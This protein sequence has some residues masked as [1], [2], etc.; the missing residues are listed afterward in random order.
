MSLQHTSPLQHGWPN[1][2]YTLIKEA[3]DYS[4][5]VTAWPFWRGMD[6]HSGIYCKHDSWLSKMKIS[7]THII[8]T[9]SEYICE[10]NSF[11]CLS[12]SS[13]IFTDEIGVML[14]YMQDTETITA[15]CWS[16]L[17]FR[18]TTVCNYKYNWQ[19]HHY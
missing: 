7:V 12:M 10:Q 8:K 19:Y 14:T 11:K 9:N 3:F 6:S 1:K 5:F 17:R 16:Y 2:I 15:I 4:P 13:K 18:H